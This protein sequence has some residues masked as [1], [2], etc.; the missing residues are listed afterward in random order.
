MTHSPEPW[1]VRTLQGDVGIDDADGLGILGCNSLDLPYVQDPEDA[2]RIVAC[3]NFCRD[4][5]TEDLE[6]IICIDGKLAHEY[7]ADLLRAWRTNNDRQT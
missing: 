1:K 6:S 3:V 7:R 2:R 5:P 4:I